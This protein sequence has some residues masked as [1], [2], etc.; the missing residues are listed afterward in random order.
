MDYELY[1]GYQYIQAI[2]P[3]RGH[4]LDKLHPLEDKKVKW[5]TVSK[6]EKAKCDEWSVF[7]NGVIACEA[8]DDTEDCIVKIMKGEADAMSM[9]G[10][11]VYTAGKCGLVPVL[12]EN[13]LSNKDEPLGPDCENK[14]AT[15][16]SELIILGVEGTFLF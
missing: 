2:K 5:C 9:D 12:V 3:M 16:E 1:L 14:P 4:A 15:G 13:Y 6:E 8:A 11:Y 10:G 7:S